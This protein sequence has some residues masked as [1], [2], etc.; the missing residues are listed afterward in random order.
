MD[1]LIPLV[2]AVTI[3]ALIVIGGAVAA[4]RL[5]PVPAT[6]DNI[7]A[8]RAELSDLQVQFLD[9]ADRYELSV[10]RNAAKV[11]KLRRKLA[12]AEGDELVEEDEVEPNP[13]PPPPTTPGVV[14]MSKA[15]L[16]NRAN[17]RKAAS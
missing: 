15:D 1:S 3:G 12:H 13:A 6:P 14:Q 7:R 5:I 2:L 4:L 16:W 17:A 10:A 9:F 11:G 8:V